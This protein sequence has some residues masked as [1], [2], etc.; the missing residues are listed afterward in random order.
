MTK[1]GAQKISQ[2]KALGD[3]LV[4]RGLLSPANLEASLR[5]AALRQQRLGRLLVID[6]LVS[7]MDLARCLAEQ[8]SLKVVEPEAMRPTPAALGKVP[9]KLI[10]QFSI[11]PLRIE[12][13][14]LQVVVFDPV[15]V[16][17]IETVRQAA[18]MAIELSVGAESQIKLAIE[19]AYST[20]ELSIEAMGLQLSKEIAKT[21]LLAKGKEDISEAGGTVLQFHNKEDNVSVE[22]LVGSLIEEAVEEKASDIHLEATEAGIRVRVRT[23]GVLRERG[24]LP[25]DL[26]S[27]LI[28]RLKVLGHL[29]IAEK[30]KAQDGSFQYRWGPQIVDVRLSTLPTVQGEKAVLRILD[31]SI[32]KVG[33]DELG[34]G[35]KLAEEVHG[36]TSRPHG[37]LL[38]TGPTGCGKTTTVYSLMTALNKG[39]K[40]IVSIED[41]I[42]YLVDGINQVQVLAKA[43]TT[44]ASSLRSILRQDPDVLIVGEIRDQ[45]T[46]EI[47]I[48]AALTGHLVISTLHT[49]DALSTLAR[50]TDMGIEPYLIASSLLGI[51]SQRLVRTLCPHC[52]E[53]GPV[54]ESD[55]ALFAGVGLPRE[56]MSAHPE[57]CAKCHASGYRGRQAIFELLN[58][59]PALRRAITEKKSEHEMMALLK[60]SGFTTMRENGLEKVK[61]GLTTLSDVLKQTL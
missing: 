32:L 57:G 47:A 44:F 19:K 41:P 55:Q 54:P 11:L 13:G 49:N 9:E 34:M 12:D 10:R 16:L 56:T 6:G 25:K 29:D 14:V 5:K 37:L 50:L 42:E 38:V 36:L 4:E 24:R 43:G 22:A 8:F 35:K 15:S 3:I 7:D 51:V 40:N 39:D 33:L 1:N 26:H 52:K 28:S 20:R 46:A 21:K 61:E 53:R 58:P 2:K 48:R 18:G 45:E 30:R 59:N 27:V 60:S 17:E 23:D 31:K